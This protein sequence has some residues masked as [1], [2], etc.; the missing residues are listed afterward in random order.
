M[1]LIQI[2][3]ILSFILIFSIF[4]LTP[5]LIAS[6]IID[7]ESLNEL[8]IKEI[9]LYQGAMF[10]RRNIQD[11]EIPYDVEQ[12]IEGI[13]EAHKQGEQLSFDENKLETSISRLKKYLAEK[14]Q[15]ERLIEAN[16]F[17]ESIAKQQG[18]YEL[19]KGKLYYKIIAPGSGSKVEYDGT[20]E[21]LYSI[22]TL[23]H[24]KEE[25]F[26]IDEPQS[27]LLK[28]TIAG[29]TKGVVGMQ[30]GEKRI[31]YVHPDLAYGSSSSKVKPNSLLIFEI[32]VVKAK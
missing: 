14:M 18:I 25:G 24:G 9:S 32:E 11:S 23:E 30:K 27:V 15:R 10:Y 7:K 3:L 6:S 1:R 13:R 12:I 19:E 16:H 22:A 4:A 26:Q 8:D 20:P 31:L 28:S 21:L 2:I 5:E 17:L 29:F